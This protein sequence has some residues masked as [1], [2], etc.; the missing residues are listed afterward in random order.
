MKKKDTAA[1]DDDLR[2]EYDL[3]ALLP[4]GTQGKYAERYRQG[5]NLICLDPEL[6]KA[7]PTEESVNSALRLVLEL[8]KIPTEPGRRSKT[9][10]SR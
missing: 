6:A 1:V 4:R 7:F 2:P 9:T 5:T 10:V 3:A 8:T